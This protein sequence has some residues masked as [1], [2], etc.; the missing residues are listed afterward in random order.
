MNRKNIYYLVASLHI[1]LRTKNEYKAVMRLDATIK[2]IEVVGKCIF[3]TNGINFR[4]L[5]NTNDSNDR[6]HF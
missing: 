1:Y 2:Y 5:F 4:T 6:A 3:R